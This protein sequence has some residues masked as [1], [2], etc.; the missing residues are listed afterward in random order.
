MLLKKARVKLEN[1][2]KRD[3][4][5]GYVIQ[6]QDDTSLHKFQVNRVPFPWSLQQYDSLMKGVIIKEG[7]SALS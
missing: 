1:E 5:D 3:D 7:N 2:V 6:N 4:F